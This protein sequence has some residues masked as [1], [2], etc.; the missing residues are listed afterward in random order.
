MIPLPPGCR[1]AYSIVIEI[2]KLTDEIGEWFVTIG[3]RAWAE[4]EWDHYGRRS[5]LKFVQYGKGK[6]SY[7]HKSGSDGIR[8]HFDGADASVA[9]M[10]LLKFTDH[11][12]SHNLKEM[13]EYVY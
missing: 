10:F 8:L 4:E 7:V 12:R 11:V 2:D 13:N 3:G 1:V 6:R 5:L 9:S